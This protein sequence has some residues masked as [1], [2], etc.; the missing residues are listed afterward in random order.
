MDNAEIADRL[1][2]WI[3]TDVKVT[4][5]M[6]NALEFAFANDPSLFRAFSR[7]VQAEMQELEDMHEAGN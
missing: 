4:Q 1:N 6:L 3:G 5:E 7:N 2:D